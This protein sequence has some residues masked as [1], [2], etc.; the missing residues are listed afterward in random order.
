MQEIAEGILNIL[1]VVIASGISIYLMIKYFLWLIR[2]TMKLGSQSNLTY[3]KIFSIGLGLS[4]LHIISFLILAII[5]AFLIYASGNWNS[6][7]TTIVNSIL[8]I[9]LVVIWGILIYKN[10]YPR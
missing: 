10:F 6:G 7:A 4:V 8:V 5:I 1:L 9:G 3:I 2:K